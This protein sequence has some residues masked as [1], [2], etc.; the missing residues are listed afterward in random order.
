MSLSISLVY[1]YYVL[2]RHMYY[3]FVIY[4]ELVNNAFVVGF[5]VCSMQSLV[6]LYIFL[7]YMHYFLRNDG[8]TR[9]AVATEVVP[10]MGFGV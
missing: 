8:A 7:I 3:V 1:I 4:L 6:F 2:I 9:H 10:S 5:Y